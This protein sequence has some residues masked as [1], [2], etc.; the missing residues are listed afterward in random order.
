V[1]IFRA[2]F[3]EGVERA[4]SVPFLATSA[5]ALLAALNVWAL[6][7]CAV[8]RDGGEA[9][10]SSRL[11]ERAVMLRLWAIAFV[12]AVAIGA[13]EVA[14]SLRGKQV[15]AMDASRIGMMFAECSLVMFLVQVLVFSPLIRPGATRWFFAPALGILAVGLVLV[16]LATSY[17]ATTI[18][19]AFVAASAGV[20][21]PIATYWV[22]LGAGDKQGADLGRATAAASLGQ[23][24]GSA[25][26]G[27]LFDVSALPNA[28]FTVAAGIVLAGLA[29]SLGLPR[30]LSVRSPK[31]P[32]NERRSHQQ[33][34]HEPLP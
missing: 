3:A 21:S 12:T 18:A 11:V 8:K 22:S 27:L 33:Q 6:A 10:A 16:P 5:L 13:F 1:R 19:V 9:R 20:L 24:F 14:L 32:T 2:L 28:A 31:M 23:A 7:P 17:M 25:T 15:L 29:A 34:C 30:D 4:F 26:G